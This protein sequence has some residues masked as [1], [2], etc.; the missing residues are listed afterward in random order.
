MRKHA[1]LDRLDTMDFMKECMREAERKATPFG[2]KYESSAT[3]INAWAIHPECVEF[4]NLTPQDADLLFDNAAEAQNN[5]SRVI[6][7]YFSK[8]E[9]IR[10]DSVMV[11]KVPENYPKFG[12]GVT[13]QIY[14]A[15]H[16][17]IYY[18][19]YKK[20]I[21][22]IQVN[23]SLPLP[24]LDK[25]WI[26]PALFTDLGVSNDTYKAKVLKAYVWGLSEGLIMAYNNH[27]T[28]VWGYNS[29]NNRGVSYFKGLNGRVLR[30]SIN[31]LLTEGLWN[32]EKIVDEI[33]ETIEK[34]KEKAKNIWRTLRIE[35]KSI[36]SV[37][38]IKHFVRY[39]FK[40][41]DAFS[42][43]NL[44]SIFNGYLTENDSEALSFIMDDIIDT[45]TKI[46]GNKGMDTKRILEKIFDRLTDSI[47]RDTIPLTRDF[48]RNMI[49]DRLEKLFE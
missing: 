12:S 16:Q 14:S 42:D 35:G 39:K 33:L 43:R 40:D 46:T 44:L 20:R 23:P 37:D 38:L 2:A 45:V 7:D 47:Q 10:E 4:Q 26:S 13:D 3:K 15:S 32:N 28:M 18:Q 41:F 9:I 30:I 49:D 19:Y 8:T 5:A 48:V 6:S 1:E 22:E 36:L 25:R 24:H 34:R 31:N 17:G 29:T 27:G 11:L 21:K